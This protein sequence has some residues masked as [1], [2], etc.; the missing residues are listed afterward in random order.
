MSKGAAR[1]AGVQGA[2]SKVCRGTAEEGGAAEAGCG[3]G[4]GDG[5]HGR[6]VARAAARLGMASHIFLPAHASERRIE[7][8]RGEGAHVQV[9]VRNYDEAVR[10]AAREAQ[11]RGW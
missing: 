8:I 4:G 2:G 11:A 6:A 3:A 5:N 7:S 9:A 10:R 1:A